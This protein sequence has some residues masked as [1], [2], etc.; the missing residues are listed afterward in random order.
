MLFCARLNKERV[1][2]KTLAYIFAIPLLSTFYGILNTSTATAV[3]ET[4]QDLGGTETTNTSTSS[5]SSE[6]IPTDTSV[7]S[8]QGSVAE[9]STAVA[10][11]ESTTSIL[12]VKVTQLTEVASSISQDTQTATAVQEATAAVAAITS[13]TQ[14]TRTAE[15]L[16]AN[17]QILVSSAALESTTATL[18]STTA[19]AET[20]NPTTAV[21]DALANANTQ[22]EEAEQAI[23]EA[24]DA[25]ATAENLAETSPT[26]EEAT[27]NLEQATTTHS[28]AIEDVDAQEVVVEQATSTKN[29]A[30]E[31][32]DSQTTTGLNVTIYSNPGTAGSPQM[33]GT[34]V[35]T[36]TDT[37]GINE[38]WGG[39]GP[40]VN[41]GT[42]TVTETFSGN[43][44]N[45]SIGITVN[46]TPVSTTNN[47]GVY[48]GSIGFPGPGQDPSL[49]LY[50][51]TATTVI[52]MPA[53]TTSAGF[54][55]FAKN[56]NTTGLITYTD[57]TTETYI[58][59][60][61]VNPQYPN[62][63]HRE[64]FTA[65]AGKTIATVT[66]PADWDYFAIDNVSATKPNTAVVVE[67]FQVR[68]QGLWTPQT[69]GTQYITAPADDGVKLYLDGEL[70]IND[71]VDKGGGGST[72]DVMTTA[73]VAKAFEM[74]YYEN[75]GGA[76][77][78][79]LRYTDSGW[80][81]VPASEFS[82]SSATPQ[83]IQQLST[84]ITNLEIAQDTLEVLEL[85]EDV[86]A[87]EVVEAQ[88]N[89]AAAHTAV[90]AMTDAINLA[91]EAV[92]E[93]IQAVSAVQT[94]QTVVTQELIN[95][96]PINS[97]TNISV[98]QLQNGD[99]QVSWEAPTGLV[100]PERYAISWSVDGQG[101][102]VATG[103]AGDENALTT[104]IVLSAS[105]FESTG[106]LDK[107]Y[108][109]TVRSDND[110]LAKYSEQVVTQ[111]LIL[112]PTPAPPPPPPAP[113]PQPE[114]QPEPPVVTP[115]PE[116]EPEPPVVIPDPEPEP[117]PPV[118]P[119]PEPEPPVDPEPE[120]EPQPE[121][122]PSPEP[123]PKPEPNPEP[124]PSPD[125]TPEETTKEEI[126]D[127]VDSVIGDGKLS[128]SDSEKILDA[129]NADGEITKDEVNNL[130]DALAADGKL[131]EAEKD[132]V[133]TALIESVAP[134][135]NLTKEQIQDA[136]I[137]Y[138]DLPPET[139]VEVR[140][141][142]NGN[143][144]V[145]I[146]EVAAALE[147]VSDPGAL[148]DALFSDP[149]QALLAMASLGADMSDEE[150]EEAGKM[151]LTVVVAGQAVA[152]AL[153]AAA[154]AAGGTGSSSGGGTG[155]GGSGGGAPSG[156]SATRRR[157]P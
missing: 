99:V 12:E 120:P 18:E 56:G 20:L 42:T 51:P 64:T 4:P 113:E 61:N 130:S 155:G 14:E 5:A 13:S 109:I 144:I 84:A 150:R 66:V 31:V 11:A 63:V 78:S 55:M 103:N 50:S 77:V 128:E 111:L 6:V 148:V 142:E 28:N 37:D 69:T 129:L 132:L 86:A 3:D 65:P 38:Q 110:S 8:T 35:Y 93:T 141:D 157:R 33:G 100:A 126:S 153:A 154:P 94:A 101:W 26:V 46:G 25:L 104:S 60:D 146:A 85:A 41:S 122:E 106:G 134:G 81:V 52:T 116:P 136:G 125:T 114:P 19:I 79:L 39:S 43:S 58:L 149:G 71:W 102:G 131:T 44:L 30:Q 76:S 47:S 89:L 152:T 48:I 75:S 143:E 23:A 133:A 147:L 137:E 145:I 72:A 112:D 57:G 34:V 62:Y 124:S 45:T 21:T 138:K 32:V 107:T 97:P 127:A 59:Q 121:P 53:G 83:Q 22:I 16:V 82:T 88:S 90:V 119:A 151:V 74:W 36:G 105:L 24:E 17:A 67:D 98:V 92:T 1:K 73:G 96:T 123:E 91:Q 29:F 10:T 49:S 115:E 139:P 54:E 80:V 117:E 27:S 68:W 2:I 70:V 95:Q 118:D 15:V 140:R 7:E 87:Q 108:E 40:T 9:S 156:G 135:E